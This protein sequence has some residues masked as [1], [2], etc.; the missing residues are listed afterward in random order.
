VPSCARS[1][2]ALARPPGYLL[3]IPQ[4]Q[5][6]VEIIYQ[7]ES[8]MNSNLADWFFLKMENWYASRLMAVMLLMLLVEEPVVSLAWAVHSGFKKLS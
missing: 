8:R 6:Q 5:N 7:S 2:Q 3:L 1:H 4:L